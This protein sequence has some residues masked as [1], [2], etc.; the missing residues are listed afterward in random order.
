M[1]SDY[2]YSGRIT[3]ISTVLIIFWP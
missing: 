1:T 2:L 3:V